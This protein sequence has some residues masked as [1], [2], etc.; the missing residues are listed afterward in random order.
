MC[1]PLECWSSSRAPV[2]AAGTDSVQLT[3][4]TWLHESRN[5][6]GWLA[7]P[8]SLALTELVD[9]RCRELA[10]RRRLSATA[11]VGAGPTSASTSSSGLGPRSHALGALFPHSHCSTRAPRPLPLPPSP[12]PPFYIINALDLSCQILTKTV[13]QELVNDSA[14]GLTGIWGKAKQRLEIAKHT[15]SGL[16]SSFS[17]RGG[18]CKELAA[19]ASCC[20]FLLLLE[21]DNISSAC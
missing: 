9:E 17:K 11:E 15:G 20:C 8:F 4:A 18:S 2:S 16:C 6:P 12:G 10:G 5:T 14:S 1:R 21:T 3:G 19:A 13:E 7:F